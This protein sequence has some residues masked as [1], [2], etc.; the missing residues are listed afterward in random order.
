M[1]VGDVQG[2]GIMELVLSGEQ[3]VYLVST[4][5]L[6]REGSYSLDETPW[7]F[8]RDEL[9]VALVPLLFDLDG[10]GG[11]DLLLGSPGSTPGG[12]GGKG[13]AAGFFSPE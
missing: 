10:D 13:S 11:D 3:R 7:S 4:D 9:S 8:T 2:D 6:P 12:S 5:M 1:D